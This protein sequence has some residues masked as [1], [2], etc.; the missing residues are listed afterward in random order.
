[1]GTVDIEVVNDPSG[2]AVVV[3]V[4]EVSVSTVVALPDFAAAALAAASL[5]GVSEPTVA[6][7]GPD[8]GAGVLEG[9]VG[10][11]EGAGAD[12]VADGWDDGV[13]V[14]DGVVGAALGDDDV[15]AGA[16]VWANAGAWAVAAATAAISAVLQAT[17][18]ESSARIRAGRGMGVPSYLVDVRHCN[19]AA[20]SHPALDPTSAC[21]RSLAGSAGTT[22]AGR[23]GAR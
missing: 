20:P 11:V 6:I 9:A 5:V 3:E 8:D 14:L 2:F 13:G 21:C 22:G 19:V 16:G 4:C 23:A 7:S 15:V 10:V 1:V 12:G 18:L 17:D